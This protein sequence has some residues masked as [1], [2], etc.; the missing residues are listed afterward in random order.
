MAWNSFNEKSL[1]GVQQKSILNVGAPVAFNAGMAGKPYKDSWDIERAYREGVQ[2]VTWVF[3]CIDAIA[4]NQARLPMILRKDN[5]P[6]GQVV[7]KN[8]PLL[9]ILNSKANMGENSFI[10]R[11]R[12]SSQLLMSSRGVFIEKVR[13]RDGQIIALH[14]LPPQHT[15][16]IPDP[17]TFVS[18]YEVDMRNGTKVILK[19]SD[20]IW[21]RRPHPLDP[22]LSITPMEAAGIAIELEN[23]SKLYNRNYLLNDGRPGGL[24]VVRGEMEDDDKEELRN[25]F[26]GNLS[27]TGSTTVIASEDGVDYIDTSASPRDAAY[28]QM[29]QIQKEEILSAFGVPESVI[30]NAAGRTF[31][32]A[33]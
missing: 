18:G 20:V 21:I 30:G 17:K 12:V 4:G 13:G 2:K 10:F 6:T 28:T 23:L 11:Y 33:G 14:L 22:Y 7:N 32:N 24:L 29:R 25:R 8:N 15:A 9:D 27:R 16:P 31:S 3:R 19:P 5:S 26:R 1:Q